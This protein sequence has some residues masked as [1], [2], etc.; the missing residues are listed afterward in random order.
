[1]G[2]L[3]FKMAAKKHQTPMPTVTFDDC[4]M[5]HKQTMV[6]SLVS[7]QGSDSLTLDS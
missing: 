4:S 6:V 3:Q 5:N 2:V 7:V 1:M